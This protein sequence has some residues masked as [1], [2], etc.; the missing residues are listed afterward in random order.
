M[1]AA[2]LLVAPGEGCNYVVDVSRVFRKTK[3]PS[4][5][6]NTRNMKTKK[7]I[8][9]DPPFDISGGGGTLEVSAI[10]ILTANLF[11]DKKYYIYS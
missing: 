2:S 5:I 9:V 8:I 6:I 10:R 7:I 1:L 4:E 11:R 3:A